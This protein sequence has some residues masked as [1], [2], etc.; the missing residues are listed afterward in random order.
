MNTE[1]CNNMTKPYYIVLNYSIWTHLTQNVGILK[2]FA[3]SLILAGRINV[4]APFPFFP[5]LIS[6][7]GNSPNGWSPLTF[8]VLCSSDVISRC[9]FSRIY[10]HFLLAKSTLI[11]LTK[12]I[13]TVS[14]ESINFNSKSDLWNVSVWSITSL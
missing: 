9:A 8:T 12:S 1:K 11:F 4:S 3:L 5:L 14:F 6:S 10:W 7:G 13:K 2:M